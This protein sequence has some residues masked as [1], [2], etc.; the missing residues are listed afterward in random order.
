MIA[1]QPILMPIDMQSLAANR[2]ADQRNIKKLTLFGVMHDNA[3][4]IAELTGL[5]AELA[6]RVAVLE[7]R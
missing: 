2:A 4:R 7:A 6:E 1:R 5:V 3:K